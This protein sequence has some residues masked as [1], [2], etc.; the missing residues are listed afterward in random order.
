MSKLNLK[1]LV[2]NAKEAEFDFPLCPGMKV[3]IAYANKVLLNNIREKS[4]VKKFDPETGAPFNELD[5]DKYMTNYVA[6]VVK[7]WKGFTVEHLASLVLIE[8]GSLDKTQEIDF[9][10]ETAKF[11]MTESSAFDTWVVASAKQLAN[12]RNSK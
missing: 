3:T 6:A 7:G 11:L 2:V 12:F 9:D 4:L 8:E 5:T 10:L 1:T